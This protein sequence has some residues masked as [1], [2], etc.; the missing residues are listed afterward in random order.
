MANDN[1]FKQV[2]VLIEGV[3]PLLMNPATDDMLEELRRG[4][5]AR[6]QKNLELT[7]KQEAEK[8]IIRNEDGQIGIP[9]EYLFSC[10]VNAGRLVKY[11]G[12]RGISNATS[13][14]IPSFLAIE[15]M[16]FPFADQK[17]ADKNWIADCR[18]GRI[19]NNGTAVPITRPKFMNWSFRVTLSIDTGEIAEEKVKELVKKAGSAIGLGDFRPGCRG[20]F[21]RFSIAAWEEQ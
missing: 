14:L 15:E 13:T 5:G 10:L 19:P 1:G 18:R 12:K 2:R 16:F 20:P 17:D 7:R 6:K 8:K 4:A 3:S 9:A 21:G 11:D